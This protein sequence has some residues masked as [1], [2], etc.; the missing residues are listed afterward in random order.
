MKNIKQQLLL[1]ALLSSISTVSLA[2]YTPTP[3]L[4]VQEFNGTNYLTGGVGLDERH[5]IEARRS[6][7]NLRIDMSRSD[8]SYLGDGFVQIVDYHN[9]IMLE[10]KFD[11]PILLANLPEGKYQVYSIFHG[12]V[13]KNIVTVKERSQ[14]H[15]VVHW[16][17]GERDLRVR[18][19]DVSDDHAKK[20][21]HKR[22]MQ[23]RSKMHHY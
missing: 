5:Y 14:K 16:R 15:L 23:I 8:G 7:F 2:A 10:A 11:G 18:P 22:M 17:T 4:Q 3:P 12:K 13:K 9:R 6:Q 20:M 1:A 21:H 19:H